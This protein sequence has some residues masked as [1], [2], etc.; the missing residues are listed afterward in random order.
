M[1]L[2]HTSIKY[3]LLHTS[4]VRVWKHACLHCKK[5]RYAVAYVAILDQKQRMLNVNKVHGMTIFITI[6]ID[7]N[8]SH[9]YTL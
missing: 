1:C 5:N 8:I 9:K 6:K 7:Y 3:I 4:H 2:F